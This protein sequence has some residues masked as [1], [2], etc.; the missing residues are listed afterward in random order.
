MAIARKSAILENPKVFAGTFLALL[1]SL[2]S[3]FVASAQTV[4]Y[5]QPVAVYRR[6]A[7]DTIQTNSVQIAG[8]QD[9]AQDLPLTTTTSDIGTYGTPTPLDWVAFV[10][11]G[12]YITSSLPPPFNLGNL[13]V[14]TVI[15]G[16]SLAAGGTSVTDGAA[17]TGL[18]AT[19]TVLVSGHVV[20]ENFTITTT[21]NGTY[22]Y[23]N[24][25]QQSSTYDIESGIQQFTFQDTNS[26]I[27]T[28][29]S[30][31]PGC[32]QTVS[33]SQSA[34]GS[35]SY[36]SIL[37]AP[38]CQVS[39]PVAP[40]SQSGGTWGGLAYDHLGL[41]KQGNQITIAGR[42]CALTS[43]NMA[44]N[45]AGESWNPGTLNSLLDATN[46][47][48][49]PPAGTVI[50][51]TA[52]AASNGG[53]TGP[54]VIFDNLGGW[55]NSDVNLADATQTVEKGICSGTPVPVIVG[56][57][58]PKTGKY[59]GHYVL[60]TGEVINS[61]G[62]KAFTIND[63][64]GYSTVLGTD[65][66]TGNSGY[67]NAGGQPE[68]YTRGT[69][70]DPTDLTGLSVTVDAVANLM[71]TD[72]KGVQSGFYPGN[73]NPIENISHSGAGLDEMDDDVTGDAGNPVQSVMIN[74]PT[75]GVFQFSLTGAAIGQYSL[76]IGAEASD[77]TVQ[78]SSMV[79]LTN[80]GVNVTYE[81]SYNPTAG[82]PQHVTFLA[83]FQST[84][85]DIA[86]SLA[87][88]LIDNRGIA[89]ALSTKISAASAAAGSGNSNTAKNILNAF[90]N[91]VNA[92][93]SEHINGIAPQ[94]LL[95]DANSLL[96]Q[97]Q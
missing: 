19:Y 38:G 58:S 89:N 65:S 7:P 48:T 57:K 86:N 79:G 90:I 31:A 4:V 27:E 29:I 71:V 67:T 13:S 30:G 42:G 87:L 33:G 32:V 56:V 61:D 21:G 76:I 97:L 75:A 9:P 11:I 82:T 23:T 24:S 55:A 18:T 28:N 45:F 85:A 73:P 8:C 15:N 17:G 81:L 96:G 14:L 40:I 1:V 37:A 16:V 53:S 20:T 5:P 77:G 39:P 3:P 78:T 59:P 60:I 46:G 63:P 36:S 66:S 35:Q 22:S 6:S 92:Q 64:A 51:G 44:L 91:Q 95:T 26:G 84:L 83:T 94:V 93:S 80:V 88:G 41:D 47:Y 69:V 34:A 12:G 72:P 54:P 49:P 25:Y 70:H 50:W 2:T 43:L 10:G 68:F 52:T 62:S 74:S